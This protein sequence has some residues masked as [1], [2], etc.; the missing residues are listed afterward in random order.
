MKKKPGT[1]GRVFIVKFPH[2][3]RNGKKDII[4]KQKDDISL[5]F[6]VCTVRIKS[7][8]HMDNGG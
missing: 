6:V 4:V 7:K 5:F 8:G 1:G 3:N 2:Q